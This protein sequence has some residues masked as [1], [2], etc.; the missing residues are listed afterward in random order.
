MKRVKRRLNA[1]SD[2]LGKAEKIRV[3]V[4]MTTP[5]LNA[6]NHL[7]ASG[8]YLT[9]GD[10]ILEGLRIILSLYKLEAPRGWAGRSPSPRDRLGE[11]EKRR[12]SVTM[13]RLYVEALDSLVSEGLYLNRGQ[14]VLEG[15][16]IIFRR[17]GL[18]PFG[19]IE[20]PPEEGGEGAEVGDGD[21]A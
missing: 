21:V 18:E 19:F 6:L 3:S 4:T 14:I 17:H 13:T 12:I 15:L 7:V 2:R 1:M 9:Q 5:Y 10:V 20:G 16:R 8:L 11:M